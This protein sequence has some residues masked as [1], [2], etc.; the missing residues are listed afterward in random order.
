MK[1]YLKTK[2]GEVINVTKQ[3]NFDEAVFYFTKRKGISEKDLLK[4]YKIVEG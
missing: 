3:K 4:I 2:Q 1:Y